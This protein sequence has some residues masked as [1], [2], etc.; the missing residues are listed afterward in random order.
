LRFQ[1]SQK[2]ETMHARSN[3]LSRLLGT[4]W[5]GSLWLAYT[6]RS[7][8]QVFDKT[9]SRPF[10]ENNYE[11]EAFYSLKSSKGESALCELNVGVVHQSN[12]RADPF[13]RSWNRGFVQGVWMW[14]STQY[15]Q[16]S[17]G[18]ALKL[19]NAA[20]VSDTPDMA[21]FLGYGEL[22]AFWA[23]ADWG[24]NTT[25]R[26]RSVAAD[27]SVKPA[28]LGFPK[29]DKLRLHMRYFSGYGENLLDYNHKH[30]SI[31]LGISAA[32]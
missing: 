1:I 22:E 28:A 18:I 26:T 29:S 15:S 12:G 8:W 4:N 23:W 17:H 7:F 14:P 20:S 10:R 13:S 21:K 16:Q 25:W 31:G 27:V 24:I 3:Q 30:N 19:H 9:N 11:P 6:Q 2:L 32:Y 5:E